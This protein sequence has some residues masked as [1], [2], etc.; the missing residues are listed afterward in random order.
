MLLSAK[1]GFLVRKPGLGGDSESAGVFK[2]DGVELPFVEE[3]AESR[4]G[5]LARSAE[6][7]SPCSA[8]SDFDFGT[9][10]GSD[11][12]LSEARISGWKERCF[13]RTNS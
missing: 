4:V 10:A 3:A 1:E 8:G 12:M 11:I 2:P 13:G 7:K 5:V 9:S 6:S